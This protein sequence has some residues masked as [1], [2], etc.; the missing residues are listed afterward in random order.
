LHLARKYNGEWIPA[1]GAVPFNLNGWISS[2]T[3]KEY[4]G[5]LK[6]GVAL[7]EAVE[8]ISSLN[9]ISH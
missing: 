8:G 1:D 3:G 7:L 5:Y 9:Q 4:D 2:G 6:R